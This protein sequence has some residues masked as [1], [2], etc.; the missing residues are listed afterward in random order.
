M[1]VLD[2]LL[3]KCRALLVQYRRDPTFLPRARELFNKCSRDA[4][5]LE[6]VIAYL[7]ES[8]V[9]A[10]LTGHADAGH[11]GTEC[12]RR[13]HKILCVAALKTKVVERCSDME[14]LGHSARH[15]LLTLQR[16]VDHANTREIEDSFSGVEANVKFLADSASA[17]DRTS[18]SLEAMQVVLAG[19]FGFDVV[20]RLSGGSL[21][22]MVPEWVDQ[23][24]VQPIVSVPFLWWGLNMV[25]FLLVSYLAYT[26]VG[27]FNRRALGKLT[28]RL[29]VNR[30]IRVAPL[31][32]YLEGRRLEACEADVTDERSVQKRR[33]TERAKAEWG[34]A[35]PEIEI[36][37]DT[38]N[39]FLLSVCFKIDANRTSFGE[40]QLLA[41]FN[42][43]MKSAGVFASFN[44]RADTFSKRMSIQ[45]TDTAKMLEAVEK[46][47]LS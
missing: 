28:L 37:F 3:K 11:D 47:G 8:M 15:Q 24:I 14:K 20:D 33:W 45:P 42:E 7:R 4:I 39:A 40:H 1:F 22:I 13:L 5:L 35:A 21:N 34:G 43:E 46:V 44:R 23:A 36:L 16:M 10:D 25:W 18:A 2:D 19:S 12:G 38:T 32:R 41:R 31:M 30:K 29:T 6:E 9:A 27:Y 17:T 26:C